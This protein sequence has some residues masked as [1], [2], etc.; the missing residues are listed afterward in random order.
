MADT[1]LDSREW[2]ATLRF[3]RLSPDKAR[4]AI[5]L[6]RGRWCREALDILRFNR[7]RPCVDIARTLKSAMA[8]AD[9]QEADMGKLYVKEARI[10][11][12][13]TSLRWQPKD[14]GRAHPIVKR[15]S[16]IRI[17]VAEK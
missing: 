2:R 11:M 16:H 13:P 5:D 8:N 12:G 1:A 17:V 9:E 4:L 6:I 3:A 15:T 14:R 10:D 7:M